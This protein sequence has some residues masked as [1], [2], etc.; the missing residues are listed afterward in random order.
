[1]GR[2]R[3]RPFLLVRR[4]P[5]VLLKERQLHSPKHGSSCSECFGAAALPR[6]LLSRWR[7]S[8]RHPQQLGYAVG[9]VGSEGALRDQYTGCQRLQQW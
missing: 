2:R 5:S 9:I 3:R 8:P 6:S 1:M 7:S 4:L